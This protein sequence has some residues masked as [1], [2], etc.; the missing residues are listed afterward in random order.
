MPRINDRNHLGFLNFTVLQPN[1][2]PKR[3]ASQ[4][5]EQ[6]L[7]RILATILSCPIELDLHLLYRR[8]KDISLWVIRKATRQL[9]NEGLIRIEKNG[10]LN[11]YCRIDN[12]G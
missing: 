9:A 10:S 4:V 12:M 5:P 2:K 7:N 1:P 3:K 8:N 6:V 11:C